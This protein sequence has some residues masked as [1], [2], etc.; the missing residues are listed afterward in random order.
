[1]A[2]IF[3]PADPHH[4]PISRSSP[5]YTFAIGPAEKPGETPIRR[6]VKA[7][8][9]GEPLITRPAPDV[10]TNWDLVQFVAKRYND[11]PCLGSRKVIKIH[12]ET[13][14][15]KKVVDGK[16]QSIP[17]KW[18]YFELSP[19]SYISY[20]ELEQNVRVYGSGLKSLDVSLLEV[21]GSTSADW[22]TIAL[23][24]GSQSIPI[25]TAYD[26][27]GEDGLTHS[28][29]ETEASAVFTEPT[30]IK[31]L[32]RPLSQTPDLKYVIYRDEPAPKPE[33][34]AAFK[35]AHPSIALISFSELHQKG[36]DANLPPTPPS[37]EDICCIMY[38]S[39][40][41]GT[42]KGVVLTQEN[43]VAAIAGV[44]GAVEGAVNEHDYLLTYLPLAHILEFV[45]EQACLFWGGTLGYGTVKTISDVSMRNCKGDITEFRPTV[46]VGVPA[47]WETVRKG[48]YAKI[49]ASGP[50][51]SSIFWAAYHAKG[52]MSH[53]RIPGTGIIDHAIFKKVKEA[54]GGRLRIIMNGGAA[55]S[56]ETQTFLGSVVCAMIHG[57]GLTETSAN[58]ALMSP[59]QITVGTVGAP[60]VSIEVKLVDVPETG[61]L[62][63][64]SPPQGEVWIRGGPVSKCYYRNEKETAE[65]YEDGW[66]KTGD[67]G[68][69]A[70]NGHLRIIDR[71]K[72]LV[73]TLNGEYVALEKLESVYR[74]CSVVGNICVY[75]DADHVKPI[76]IIMPAEPAFLKFVKDKGLGDKELGHL[77]HD[78]AVQKAV[79]DM[80]LDAG[81][82]GGLH[83]SEMIC[84][85]VITDE[86]WTPQNGFLTA[87]QK[88]QRKKIME[89]NKKG[90]QKVYK[91]SS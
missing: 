67:I 40:S 56:K 33:D 41:T 69:W 13:K 84:G 82:K 85:V 21:Y 65:S 90:V 75:A 80:L 39:G 61:Y 59:H 4:P 47:V 9:A 91:A 54:T 53:Y 12:E 11:K 83:G 49:S 35:E 22:L 86:E 37:P 6:S 42:P 79:L 15:I 52:F 43:V 68:E 81:K 58:G 72:N 28:L 46:M 66:F 7:S 76:A 55:I 87:A 57:Y 44:D 78:K 8:P 18:N 30:L 25:A 31:S 77:V 38:T 2:P 20:A 89:A 5:P 74:T 73:K 63:T 45:F 26:T 51:V 17:K 19:Y 50:A 10:A 71:K 60:T 48:I 62:S 14:I 29:K 16:E 64:N 23:A 27:L 24:A 1:M 36:L 70:P 88:L 32:I 3:V 34:V